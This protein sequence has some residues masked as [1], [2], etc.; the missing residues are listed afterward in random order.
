M[1][2]RRAR[3]AG[4]ADAARRVIMGFA[5]DDEVSQ[6]YLATFR[7]RLHEGWTERHN[8]QFDYWFTGE[9][10]TGAASK[11]GF[12]PLGRIVGVLLIV[13]S[14]REMQ[15]SEWETS[16]QF[17]PSPGER[18]SRAFSPAWLGSTRPVR[19]VAS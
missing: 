6:T 17:P 18:N 8:I 4:R 12:P 1:A 9:S 11:A 13:S 3:A 15:P 10:T 14:S 7:Q 16:A 5:D 2:A 19:T